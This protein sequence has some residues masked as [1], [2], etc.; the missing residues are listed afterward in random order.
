MTIENL[1]ER[2]KL[3]QEEMGYAALIDDSTPG[4]MD[5]LRDVSLATVVEIGE[6][7]NEVP[8]KPWKPLTAQSFDKVKAAEEICDI[9]VF[10]IVLFISL[11][12]EESLETIMER[13]LSKVD[14]RIKA[15]QTKRR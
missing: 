4:Q 1:Y 7:L 6:F 12:P 9:L 11:R 14:K 2:I 13:V 3:Q 10:V 15:K 5:Y 8:W